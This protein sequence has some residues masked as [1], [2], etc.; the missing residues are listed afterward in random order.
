M[1]DDDV[2]L[3]HELEWQIA[4]RRS[5]SAL[6]STASA[7]GRYFAHGLVAY[8]TFWWTFRAHG[9]DEAPFRASD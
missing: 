7:V 3:L 1:K 6:L 9:R 5:Q 2:L 8:G 4:N